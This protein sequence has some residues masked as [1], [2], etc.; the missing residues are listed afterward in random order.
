MLDILG[1]CLVQTKNSSIMRGKASVCFQGMDLI[2]HEHTSHSS[3]QLSVCASG[4]VDL[5]LVGTTSMF[6]VVRPLQ[7]MSDI[8]KIMTMNGPPR[9]LIE[10]RCAAAMLAQR[11]AYHVLLFRI[12]SL[13]HLLTQ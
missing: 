12:D 2:I 7:C 4:P 3:A 1:L 10:A 13:I 6:P 8:L 5:Y 9:R 11:L